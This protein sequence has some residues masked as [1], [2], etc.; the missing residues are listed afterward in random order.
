MARELSEKTGVDS[1]LAIR[2][3]LHVQV[4]YRRYPPH[5]KSHGPTGSGSF[6]VLAATGHVLMCDMPDRE[7]MLLVSAT[8]AQLGA[9]RPS[10]DA[11]KLIAGLAEVRRQGFA[12][13]RSQ[14]S[15]DH[16]TFAVRLPDT[17]V[18]PI[19]FGITVPEKNVTNDPRYWGDVLKRSV[20]KWLGG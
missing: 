9:D 4:I 13:G 7:V 16:I 12:F 19:A 6:L 20:R 15:P 14:R 18:E 5:P 8:N 17:T 1:L 2:N 10:V 3:K 11:R